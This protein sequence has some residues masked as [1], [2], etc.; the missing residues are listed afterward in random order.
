MAGGTTYGALESPGEPS[1]AAIVGLGTNYGNIICRI[2]GLL[3]DQFWGDR[4]GPSVAR[5][6]TVILLLSQDGYRLQ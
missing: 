6:N 2:D 5:S 1:T 4:G 3:R